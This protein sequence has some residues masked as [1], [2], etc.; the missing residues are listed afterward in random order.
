M[1]RNPARR[2]AAPRVLV[3]EDDD[4]QAQLLASVL[5]AAGFEVDIVSGG[6]VTVWTVR[7]G[8]YDVVLVDYQLPDIDGRAIANLVG[9]FMGD[10]ARPILIALTATPETLNARES[11]SDKAFDVVVGKSA[12]FDSL[13]ALI[14]SRLAL[15]PDEATR[16]DAESLLLFKEWF[17]YDAEPPHPEDRNGKTGPA[18]ILVVEDDE[19]QRHLLASALE[20]HGYIAE[21]S[22]DGLDAVRQ[23]CHG[24]YDLVLVD[25]NL[26]EMDGLAIGKVIRDLIQESVRPR[27]VA[28]TAT[29]DRLKDREGSALS[30]FDEIVQKSSDWQGLMALVDRHLRTSPNPDTRRAAAHGRSALYRGQDIPIRHQPPI[31]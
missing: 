11:G 23:I 13:I 3:V 9:D 14:N 10:A 8:R 19:F 25:Y 5:Q 2:N 31:Q 7:E 27:L 15:A 6:I 1:P 29:P 28:L 30:V 4:L 17:D 22:N 21:T 26:P 20:A 24:S 12:D 18:R 16:Q